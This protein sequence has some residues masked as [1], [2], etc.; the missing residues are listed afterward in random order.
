M[1]GD[2][3]DAHGIFL[4]ENDVSDAKIVKEPSE[5]SVEELKRWLWR[6]RQQK[7]GKKHEFVKRGKGLFKVK[8]KVD[9]KVTEGISTM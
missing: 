8:R 1:A 9:P 4:K 2:E 3:S 6:N 7:C 5:C